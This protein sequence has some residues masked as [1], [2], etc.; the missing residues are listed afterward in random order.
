M[1]GGTVGGIAVAAVAA[2]CNAAAVALQASEARRAR[3]A[4]RPGIGL[5]RRLVHRRRWTAGIALLA[6]AWPLQVTALALAS[7][8]VVQPVLTASLIVLLGIGATWLHERVGLREVLGVLAIAAGVVEIVLVAPRH[9]LTHPPT[10]PLVVAVCAMAAVVVAG[11]LSGRAVPRAALLL[12]LA[13]GIGYGGSDFA[14]KL[15]STKASAGEWG[16]AVGWLAA[17]VL[18]GVLALVDESFALQRRA[19]TSV[20]PIVAAMKVPVPVLLAL[21]IG[22]EGWG[23]AGGLAIVGGIVVV[24]AG[25]V[26]LARSA[27]V[28]A[29]SGSG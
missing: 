21:G 12:V 25:A 29:A 23:P 7:L 5:I 15:V 6:I 17:S 1:T 26:L 8:T 24:S 20:A 28:A 9:S 14:A 13:A 27:A 2:C 11:H 3:R 18:L 16:V 22:G 10:L 4:A 19:A